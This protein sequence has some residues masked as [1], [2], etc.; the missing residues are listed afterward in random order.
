M[1]VTECSRCHA[2]YG[3]AAHE[4]SCQVP[5]RTVAMTATG[6][7]LAGGCTGPYP[8]P[9]RDAW[10][11]TRQAWCPQCLEATMKPYYEQDGDPAMLRKGAL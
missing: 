3:S 11:V 5:S 8:E 10:P 7:K 6:S 2:A 9:C 4:R 1:S